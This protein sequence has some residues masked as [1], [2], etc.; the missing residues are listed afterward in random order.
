M[1]ESESRSES[2][3]SR[4]R[5]LAGEVP[6]SE[7]GPHVLC[8]VPIDRPTESAF[9]RALEIAGADGLVV[10]YHRSDESWRPDDDVVLAPADDDRFSEIDEIQ[11]ARTRADSSDA[12]LAV[13]RSVTPALG[14][15]I[16]EAVQVARISDIV[17]PEAGHQE[18]TG[19]RILAGDDS[20]A[21]AIAAVLDKPVVADTEMSP[22]LH[23]VSTPAEDREG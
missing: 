11:R 19:D 3:P 6:L 10:L 9:D 14:T 15:G 23:L 8:L 13:W 21:A 4:H 7:A 20:V 16:L 2:E 1:A 5:A 12:T 22:D 17:V 18:A